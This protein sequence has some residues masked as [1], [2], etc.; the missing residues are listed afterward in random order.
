MTKKTASD[1]IKDLASSLT[2]GYRHRPD[3]MLR[4]FLSKILGD[5]GLPE[6]I[7][8]PDSA[9]PLVEKAV[10]AY[11][12]AIRANEPFCDILGPLYMEL[13]S[14][15]GRQALGQFFTPW[16]VAQMMALISVGTA[17]ERDDGSLITTIDPA[18]GS[19]VMMLAAANAILHGQ[20]P[21]ALRRWSFSG[22]DL[23]PFCARIMAAQFIANCA[24]HQVHVGELAVF[25]GDSL[26]SDLDGLEVIVH[27]S[28]PAVPIAPALHPAR[29]EAIKSAAKSQQMDLFAQ[30][31]AEL[32]M[33]VAA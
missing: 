19:G 21:D 20:G 5:W 32:A 15:G 13:A 27:A 7:P 10:A 17:P 18:C 23:D 11:A 6:W 9:R 2:D 14:H 22:V 29:M 28:A 1:P 16:P 26:R 24:E 8:V 30:G 4:F 31:S 12:R 3:E 33:E 25:R